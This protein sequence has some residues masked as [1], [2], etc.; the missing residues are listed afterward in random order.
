MLISIASM[1]EELV[2]EDVQDGA[3]L[4]LVDCWIRLQFVSHCF[5]DFYNLFCKQLSRRGFINRRKSG[6]WLRG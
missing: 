1:R 3:A 4:F 2:V 6:M 5:C